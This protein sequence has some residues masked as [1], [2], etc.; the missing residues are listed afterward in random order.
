M[1]GGKRRL[2]EQIDPC[3]PKKINGYFEPFLG[4]GSMFF[5]LKQKYNPK[6]CILSDINRD[7][8]ETFKVVRDDPKKLMNFMRHLSKKNSKDFF[9]EIRKKFNKNKISGI[10]RCAV[11]IYLN[12]TCF[13][14]LWRV[15]SKGEFNV[16]FGG[17]KNPEIFDE[18]NIFLASKLLQGVIIK[19]QYYREILDLVGKKDFVYLDPCYDPLKRTSFAN[20]CSKRFCEKDRI[21]LAS[22]MGALRSRGA[23]VILSNNDLP[24]VREIYAT[25][26]IKEVSA[27]RSINSDPLGRGKI[28]ELVITNYR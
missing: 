11:F 9:Y 13:N 24:I 2:I 1:G 4:G 6:F 15:N 10:K 26:E 22:F 19:H 14:G 12:K 17:R 18:K 28:K 7:L 21:E 5:Y 25:F 16:P 23:K 20:Y 27:S 8:I 3:L